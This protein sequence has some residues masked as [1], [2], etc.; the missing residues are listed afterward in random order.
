MYCVRYMTGHV[1]LCYKCVWCVVVKGLCD[2]EGCVCKVYGGT[3]A[4]MLQ[5]CGGHSTG[6]CVVCRWRCA[7][8]MQHVMGDGTL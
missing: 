8:W 4:S 2:I 3:R 5:V 7:R 6:L 1:L